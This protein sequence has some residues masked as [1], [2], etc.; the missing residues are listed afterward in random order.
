MP[1]VNLS[2]EEKWEKIIACDQTYDGL[3][4]LRQ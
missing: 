2:F 4:F 1:D 3:F